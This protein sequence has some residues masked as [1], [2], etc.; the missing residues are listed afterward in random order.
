MDEPS[1]LPSPMS[2]ASSAASD[3][4]AEPCKGPC[5]GG[6]CLSESRDDARI[7]RAGDL[8]GRFARR[9]GIHAPGDA[10]RRYVWTD[11]FAV[12]A[13]LSLARATG[14]SRYRADAYRLVDLVH[15]H[16][17]THRLDDAR[18]GWISGLDGPAGELH[19][20]LGGLRIGKPLP[21]RASHVPYDDHLEW[22]RD[23]QY[24]H[25]LTRWIG[26]LLSCFHASAEPA[27]RL[28]YLEFA[29]ELAHTMH[30]AFVVEAWEGGPK[31]IRW[32]MSIDL[33]RPQVHASGLS[34]M[35][36]GYA[37]FAVLDAALQEARI[38]DAAVAHAS[39]ELRAMCDAASSFATTDALSL[40]GLLL[41]ASRL[42]Q[43]ASYGALPRDLA[44]ERLVHR[45]LCDM[46][47][48]LEAFDRSGALFTAIDRRL[49][50]RELGLAI[51]L[52]S[53]GGMR[54]AVSRSPSLLAALS[55]R[56]DLLAR[57]LQLCDRMERTWLDPAAQE[58]KSW[59]EHIDINEV[60]LA[61]CLL[62]EVALEVST[63]TAGSARAV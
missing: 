63:A 38:A 52:Q 3:A 29:R 53:I 44:F 19:P 48:G 28:R 27:T 11:A 54:I 22:E 7:A 62:P 1:Y 9:T 40:G 60:M 10:S 50:F 18:V 15:L 45:L 12:Q 37:T 21:E 51:G 26:A 24:Y 31:Q 16:L 23:G 5:L 6:P 59:Q 34:D 17:G 14:E 35:L 36:D 20:T 4:Q 39:A 13:M 42:V 8:L 33:T 55:P 32:K 41:D 61:S 58:T 57:H 25:Y 43:L 46:D 56:I 47:R 49:A 2:H 30:A